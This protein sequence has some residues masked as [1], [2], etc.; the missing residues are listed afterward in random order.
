MS[1][2]LEVIGEE[3]E[4]IEHSTLN[5]RGAVVEATLVDEC[6]DLGGE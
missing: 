2:S 1:Y 5:G 3:E 4:N 6:F